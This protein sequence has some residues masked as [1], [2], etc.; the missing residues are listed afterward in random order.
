[1]HTT[2]SLLTNFIGMLISC[3]YL[4]LY[5]SL[6]VCSWLECIGHAHLLVVDRMINCLCVYMTA[7]RSSKTLRTVSKCRIGLQLAALNIYLFRSLVY[8]TCE[9][10]EGQTFIA[11]RNSLTLRLVLVHN[12]QTKL[13]MR[14]ESCIHLFLSVSLEILTTLGLADLINTALSF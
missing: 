14:V 3:F 11:L 7:H 5:S 13:I 9:K 8:L 10:R 2:F 6:G 1:M 4:I 12:A